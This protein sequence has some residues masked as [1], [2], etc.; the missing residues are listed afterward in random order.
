MAYA[1]AA[2]E[3]RIRDRLAS[4]VDVAVGAVAQAPG[5]V[6]LVL[7]NVGSEDGVDCVA[8]ARLRSWIDVWR[9][10]ATRPVVGTPWP[11]HPGRWLH[12]C[13]DDAYDDA[14]RIV[15]P[16]LASMSVPFAFA[17]CAGLIGRRAAWKGASGALLAD[18]ALIRDT[19]ALGGTMLSHGVMHESQHSLDREQFLHVASESRDRLEQQFGVAV[20]GFVFPFGHAAGDVP[21]I[22]E[23]AGYSYA[24]TAVPGAI[25]SA[26]H[27]YLLPRCGVA[28][29]YGERHARALA[30]G[31][32]R[33]RAQYLHDRFVVE[34]TEARESE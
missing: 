7:H 2:A 28:A 12:L 29:V 27:P 15:G 14:L 34:R 21:S 5:G 8:E 22:L 24:M 10:D 25:S 26:S 4:L 19:L 13:F 30:R 16:L 23:E 11:P 6:S 31:G 17:V 9:A 18:A 1:G 33:W 3:G 20:D 32:A